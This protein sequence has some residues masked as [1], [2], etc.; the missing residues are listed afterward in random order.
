MILSKSLV[1]FNHLLIQSFFVVVAAMN[2]CEYSKLML[3]MMIFFIKVKDK[4]PTLLQG[5]QVAPHF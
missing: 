1:S 2:F 3:P 5:K 4:H